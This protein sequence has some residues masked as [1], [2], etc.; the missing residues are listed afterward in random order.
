LGFSVVPYD[1]YGLESV[2]CKT[3]V[4][5]EYNRKRTRFNTSNKCILLLSAV[6]IFSQILTAHDSKSDYGFYS[7]MTVSNVKTPPQVLN[8]SQ[9]SIFYFIPTIS[10]RFT[11]KQ[12]L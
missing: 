3:Y 1:L 6:Y 8:Y 11:W 10:S 4:Y 12:S 2:G 9:T 7:F 5:K